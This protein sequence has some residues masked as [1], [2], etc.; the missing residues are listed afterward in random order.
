MIGDLWVEHPKRES[1]DVWLG[2]AIPATSR[3]RPYA[4]DQCGGFVTW[5]RS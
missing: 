4:D 3:K 2:A 5:R 1:F